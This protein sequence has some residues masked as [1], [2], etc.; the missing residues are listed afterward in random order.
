MAGTTA[1]SHS[2]RSLAV[3]AAD[4]AATVLSFGANKLV[5]RGLVWLNRNSL[6][7]YV[8]PALLI[9]EALGVYRIYLTGGAVGWW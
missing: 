9:N 5:A 6:A 7:R 1:S 2:S 4:A 3:R 8:L